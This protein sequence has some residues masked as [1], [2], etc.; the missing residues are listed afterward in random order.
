MLT[1]LDERPVE[2]EHGRPLWLY[3]VMQPGGKSVIDT[4]GW[5]PGPLQ[6]GPAAEAKAFVQA[7]PNTLFAAGSTHLYIGD[8]QTY[9]IGQ[10][11]MR[12][13]LLRRIRRIAE[14]VP[15]NALDREFA[16]DW[17]EARPPPNGGADVVFAPSHPAY[18]QLLVD[19]QDRLWV[20]EAPRDP[21]RQYQNWAVYDTA[22]TLLRDVVLPFGFDQVRAIGTD[23][24]L[25]RSANDLLIPVLRVH[26]LADQHMH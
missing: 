19:A 15:V 16:L 13:E 17:L 11:D 18:S 25:S 10:Y 2:T 1:A 8:S 5:F 26:R 23:R 22:G 6:S 14:R 20:H 24:V 3:G 21:K 9:E 7:S 4:I 12:G